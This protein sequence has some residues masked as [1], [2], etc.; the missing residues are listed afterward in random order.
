[1]PTTITTQALAEVIKSILTEAL[2]KLK[3]L[4]AEAATLPAVGSLVRVLAVSPESAHYASRDELIGKHLIVTKVEPSPLGAPWLTLGSTLVD[5]GN[6]LYCYAVQV[7]PAAEPVAHPASIAPGARVK[8][9]KVPGL[10]EYSG[11]EATIGAGG[12]EFSATDEFYEGERNTYRGRFIFGKDAGRECEGSY[13]F[14]AVT[15]E[16]LTIAPAAHPAPAPIATLRAR[17]YD[18]AAQTTKPFDAAGIAFALSVDNTHTVASYL[19]EACKAGRIKRVR[20][21]WYVGGAK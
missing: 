17:V 11:K 3:A 13:T 14:R 12:A 8:I 5:G 6:Y 20:Q 9:V 10:R 21:G 16:V 19:A 7:E 2:A 18:L 4:S 15:L 1:M